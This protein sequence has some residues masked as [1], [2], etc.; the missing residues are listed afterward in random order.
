MYIPKHSSHHHH[1]TGGTD[2]SPEADH[3]L[4]N[5]PIT[6]E[7][8]MMIAV[9]SFAMLL[10]MIGECLRRCIAPD[11]HP[12]EEEA[13]YNQEQPWDFTLAEDGTLIDNESGRPRQYGTFYTDGKSWYNADGY[14]FT[15]CQPP[16][17]F[18]S[19]KY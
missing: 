2:H 1:T 5:N 11:D 10:M 15:T 7:I 3:D 12:G 8:I 9:I 16:P 4:I 17:P 14:V 19:Q 6:I 13:A 18:S